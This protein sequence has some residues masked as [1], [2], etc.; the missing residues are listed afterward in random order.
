MVEIIHLSEPFMQLEI[1]RVLKKSLVTRFIGPLSYK[2]ISGPG[3]FSTL[4]IMRREMEQ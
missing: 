4:S 2:N 1:M 3:T